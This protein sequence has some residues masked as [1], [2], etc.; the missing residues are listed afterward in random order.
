MTFTQA[1]L[2]H[3][4]FAMCHAS[5]LPSHLRNICVAA[6]VFVGLILVPD[7]FAQ[8]LLRCDVT[9]AGRTHVVDASPI[10]DPYSVSS[11]DIAGRFRFKAVMVGDETRLASINLYVYFVGEDGQP[12]LVQQSKYLPIERKLAAPMAL[13]GT[14][15]LYAGPLEREL[16]YSC[17]L[18][19]GQ[20]K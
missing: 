18:E 14:Q 16:I 19:G 15:Y 4:A 2:H 20:P 13:T 11:V 12:K 7:A 8:P 1:P 6:M 10:S 3:A 5:N 17:S 9:Y